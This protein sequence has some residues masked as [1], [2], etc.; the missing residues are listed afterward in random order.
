MVAR[1]ILFGLFLA[2][3]FLV[4]MRLWS[5]QGN[6]GLTQWLA[7]LLVLITAANTLATFSR[8]LPWQNVLAASALITL[9]SGASEGFAVLAGPPLTRF[10]AAGSNWALPLI[11]LVAILNAR[12]VA[13]LILRRWRKSTAYGL[14]LVG[15]AA[16]LAAFFGIGLRFFCAANLMLQ[17]KS[18]TY[19][20]LI[21]WAMAA[22]LALVVA[23][24][25]L[26]DKRPAEHLP[27]LQPMITWML[28]NFL[29]ASATLLTNSWLVTVII[30][31]AN[32]VILLVVFT[33]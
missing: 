32:A 21:Y 3:W 27:A 2:Q 10:V 30:V 16:L 20:G 15:L 4:W 24:P 18:I 11:W 8:E 7:C 6:L 26:I 17:P 31:M 1:I 14:W 19:L 5:N 28:L 33:D 13:R 22:A 12:G 9:V 29:F 23:T 25:W